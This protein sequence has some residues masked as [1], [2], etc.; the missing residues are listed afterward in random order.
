MLRKI[1][2]TT[3]LLLCWAWANAQNKA[4]FLY[5]GTDINGTEAYAYVEKDLGD[6]KEVWEK[7]VLTSI[8]EHI[9]QRPM[10]RNSKKNKSYI[11]P[12][13]G[14]VKVQTYYNYMQYNCT[15]GKTK[16]L[17]QIK[18]N[19]TND[20]FLIKDEDFSN[21]N[22]VLKPEEGSNTAYMLQAICQK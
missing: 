9:P 7:Y 2:A 5:A 1:Y 14:A 22:I 15:D 11:Q 19:G 17:R 20:D 18:T 13:I 21:E 3:G 6:T 8:T 12:K 16:A 4:Q 10:R